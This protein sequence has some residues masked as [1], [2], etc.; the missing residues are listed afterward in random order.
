MTAV[1][2][3]PD[4]TRTVRVSTNGGRQALWAPD[5]RTI[6]YRDGHDVMAVPVSTEPSLEAGKPVALF[7]DA[8]GGREYSARH[9][10]ITADGERF[11]MVEEEPRHIVVVTD[12]FAELERLA[13]MEPG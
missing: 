7:R 9:Y 6:Y 3:F 5:G 8:F 4:R 1:T 12:F 10:D 2:D 13:P 11:L